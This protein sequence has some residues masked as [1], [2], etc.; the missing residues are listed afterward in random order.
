MDPC[1]LSCYNPSLVEYIQDQTRLGE[2]AT[3]WTGDNETV[4]L[5]LGGVIALAL[6]TLGFVA[7]LKGRRLGALLIWL[8]LTAG[9]FWFVTPLSWT[10]GWAIDESIVSLGI[11]VAAGVALLFGLFATLRLAKPSSWWAQRR[12]ASEKYDQ[13]VERHGWSRIRAR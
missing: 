1:W 3:E 2:W 7:W 12:Y 4:L 8:V 6:L 11:G 5:I 10:E 9:W 13:A